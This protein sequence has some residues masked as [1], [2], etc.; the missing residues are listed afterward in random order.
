MALLQKLFGDPNARAVKGLQAQVERINALEPE[1]QKLK[2]ADFPEKTKAL[3][4]R[5]S[6]GESLDDLLPEAFALVREAGKRTIKQR[7]FDVQL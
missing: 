5:F 2:D 7:H 1:V 4:N 3:Y 6:K